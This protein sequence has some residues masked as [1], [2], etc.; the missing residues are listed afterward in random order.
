MS[1]IVDEVVPLGTGHQSSGG[2]TRLRVIEESVQLGSLEAKPDRA[3]DD[4]DETVSTATR[5]R[6]RL[7]DNAKRMLVNLDKHG[8]VDDDAPEAEAEDADDKGLVPSDKPQV[9]ADA[10]DAGAASAPPVDPTPAAAAAVPDEHAVRADR[11]T[12]HNRKLVAELESLRSRPVRG[13]PSARDRSLDEAERIYLEDPIKSIR[14]LVAT[15]IGVD[16]PNSK[17]VDAELTGLYQ[18]LTERELSVSLDP[19]QKASREAARTRKLLERDKRERK[20]ET[21]D[22]ASKAE[23]DAEVRQAAEVATLIGNRLLTSKHAERYPLLMT[24]AHRID[25]MKPEDLIWAG[26]R[27]GIASGELDPKTSDDQLIDAVSRKIEPYYQ[28]LRDALAVNPSPVTA[29]GTAAPSTQASPAAESKA[30]PTG[31]G[32]R[33][34]TNASASVA[35]ATPPA[36]KAATDDTKPKYRNE[37]ERRRALA[38]KYFGK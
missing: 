20:A 35:P 27:R 23:A 25:G 8:T 10:T 26:I 7:S 14:R 31:Q 2:G 32:T 9:A 4:N 17:D 11:L 1:E 6:R 15:A 5:V 22:A 29:T 33:T 34:I 37:R 19:V 12:E 30:G 13:E 28:S 38:E 18:D 24:H 16:D 3:G 36:I 21:T